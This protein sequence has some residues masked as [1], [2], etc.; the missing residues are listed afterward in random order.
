[1]A[2]THSKRLGLTGVALTQARNN[3]YDT[4]ALITVRDEIE[5]VLDQQGY[6]DGATFS[7]VTV[8]VRYGLINAEEPIYQPISTKY[9][10]LPLAIEVDTS[11]LVGADIAELRNVFKQAVVLALIHAGKRYGRPT[12]KI[13]ELLRQR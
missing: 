1:M 12:A 7:W 13:E 2:T 9:G 11:R 8:A 5:A 6:L 4:H 3:R 10:D